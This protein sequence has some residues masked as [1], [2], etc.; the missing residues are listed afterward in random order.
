MHL[1]SVVKSRLPLVFGG[2]FDLHH[3]L[4]CCLG[5]VLLS[6]VVIVMHSHSFLMG[7]KMSMMLR[8]TS[9]AAIYKKVWMDGGYM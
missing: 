5:L 1:V 3:F 6:L 4:P 8:I 7:Q 9:T 2:F